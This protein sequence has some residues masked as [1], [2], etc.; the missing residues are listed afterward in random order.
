MNITLARI[1][2]DEHGTLG[3]LIPPHGI[4]WCYTLEDPPQAEKIPGRTRIPAGRYELRLRT[5]GGLHERYAKRF[6]PLHRGMLWLQDVPGFTWVCVHSGNGT[7]DTAGCPLVGMRALRAAD[8]EPALLD[9]EMAY[10]RIYRPV[11]SALAGGE[12]TWL[13]VKE[14]V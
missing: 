10:V 12:R 2:S 6:G 8:G 11:A 9:S 3:V 4:S 1:D 5:E 7:G 14:G 13:D